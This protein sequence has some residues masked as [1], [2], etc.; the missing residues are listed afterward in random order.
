[1]KEMIKMVEKSNILTSLMDDFIT[2]VVNG[3]RFAGKIH[4]HD[5]YFVALNPCFEKS[6][7]L[8]YIAKWHDDANNYRYGIGFNKK[9]EIKLIE[10]RAYLSAEK[11]INRFVFDCPKQEKPKIFG[12]SQI[13]ELDSIVTSEMYN[14]IKNLD[15]TRKGGKQDC[16]K[17]IRILEEGRESRYNTRD[18][19]M[20]QWPSS[21][22]NCVIPLIDL[23]N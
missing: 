18:S 9:G 21:S 12:L 1:M 5:D 6:N 20:L 3:H 11:A 7:H 14:S 17:I 15:L 23:E 10:L 8:K 2:I 13:Q 19:Y 16:E 4:S 22:D